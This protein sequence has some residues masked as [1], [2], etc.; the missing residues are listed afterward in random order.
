MRT[1]IYVNP[2]W[3]KYDDCNQ[4]RHYY[5]SYYKSYYKLYNMRQ[6]TNLSSTSQHKT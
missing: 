5:K 4:K 1:I 6:R 2:N 3:N